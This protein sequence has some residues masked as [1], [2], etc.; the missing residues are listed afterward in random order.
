VKKRKCCEKTKESFLE[1]KIKGTVY[2]SGGLMNR[3]QANVGYISGSR[4][5]VRLFCAI[6]R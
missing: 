2:S 1:R 4:L 5:F 6:A 3:R